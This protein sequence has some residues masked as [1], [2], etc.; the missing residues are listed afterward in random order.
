MS[1]KGTCIYTD[2]SHCSEVCWAVA[3]LTVCGRRIVSPN[4][5]IDEYKHLEAHFD[6]DVPVYTPTP[7]VLPS[8]DKKTRT[9]NRCGWKRF[10]W[11]CKITC[12][13]CVGDAACP[14]RQPD[15]EPAP[16]PTRR[17]QA[18]DQ[19]LPLGAVEST[20]DTKCKQKCAK[21]FPIAVRE[22]VRELRHGHF[23]T[24]DVIHCCVLT[25]CCPLL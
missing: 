20:C 24:G 10:S 4:G 13:H 3:V 21:V 2:T 18:A 17:G 14:L 1:R 9:V 6:Y 5:R 15:I 22:K 25:H 8:P 16:T 12:T 19:T 23:S 7:E 11:R